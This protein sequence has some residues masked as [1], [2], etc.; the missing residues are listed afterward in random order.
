MG[1]PPPPPVKPPPTSDDPP[2]APEP[3]PDPGTGGPPAEADLSEDDRADLEDAR[4]SILALL[5]YG[6][7]VSAEDFD[8]D[9]TS[10][11]AV[12]GTDL[13]GAVA[14]VRTSLELLRDGK[15]V[16]VADRIPVALL[17]SLGKP[18]GVPAVAVRAK[19]ASD[20]YPANRVASFTM[21]KAAAVGADWA[22][23]RYDAAAADGQAATL[24]AVCVREGGVWKVFL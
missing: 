3:D 10:L 15:D 13:P 19:L 1:T 9:D 24:V 4:K 6:S 8:T 17:P 2:A 20:Y 14:A 5:S 21:G 7:R 22:L 12:K 16:A 23:V 11:P 18:L